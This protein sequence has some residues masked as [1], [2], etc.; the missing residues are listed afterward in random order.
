MVDSIYLVDKRIHFAGKDGTDVSFAVRYGGP[1]DLF[2]Y[3]GA[4][5]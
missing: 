4:D 2:G 1:D 5:V 3:E